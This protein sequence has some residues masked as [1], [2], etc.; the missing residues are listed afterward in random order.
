VCTLKKH[1]LINTTL[2]IIQ[3]L[4]SGLEALINTGMA[5]DHSITHVTVWGILQKQPIKFTKLEL[6][7]T[8]SE[9][10][11]ETFMEGIEKV[12]AHETD[13]KKTEARSIV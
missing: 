3:G 11:V 7:G 9:S 1:F 4:P 2:T 6:G 5:E 8:L 13:H 10:D 12:D